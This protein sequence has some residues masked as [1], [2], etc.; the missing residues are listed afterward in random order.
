MN[1]QCPKRIRWTKKTKGLMALSVCQPWAWLIVNGLKNVAH[2]SWWTRH[3]GPLLIHASQS[4]TSITFDV[5]DELTDEFGIKILPHEFQV[6]G[7]V[8]VVDVVDCVEKSQSPCIWEANGAGFWRTPVSCRSA[9]ARRPWA[10]SG[11]GYDSR[12]LSDPFYPM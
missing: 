12:G 3:R 11:R 5:L 4:T 7:I 9:N 2:R 8:G 1:A 6:G 10:S